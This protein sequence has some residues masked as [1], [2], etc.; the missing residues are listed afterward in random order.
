MNTFHPHELADR[1]PMPRADGEIVAAEY[2][3]GSARRPATLTI[4]RIANGCRERVAVYE[5]TGKREA[6]RVATELNAQP[7]N[8]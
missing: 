8:F 5:V 2:T 4:N 6:R 3:N 7:W 1:S